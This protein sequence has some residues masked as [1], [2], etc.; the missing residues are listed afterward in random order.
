M[1]TWE[2]GQASTTTI[3]TCTLVTVELHIY[4]FMLELLLRMLTLWLYKPME[5]LQLQQMLHMLMA[6]DKTLRISSTMPIRM[7]LRKKSTQRV[8]V[9]T[10]E[11]MPSTFLRT[12]L[13]SLN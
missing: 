1:G 10:T 5:A 6:S 4:I 9:A 7:V 8:K 2:Q 12:N 3:I 11:K 13:S